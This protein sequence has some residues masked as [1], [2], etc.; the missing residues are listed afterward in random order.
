MGARDADGS[1]PCT[2]SDFF[3]QV[4]GG[5]GLGFVSKRTGFHIV[6]TARGMKKVAFTKGSTNGQKIEIYHVDYLQKMRP[7]MCVGGARRG[8]CV[9]TSCMCQYVVYVSVPLLACLF[10]L[11]FISASEKMSQLLL[12]NFHPGVR[13]ATGPKNRQHGDG[14]LNSGGHRTRQKRCVKPLIETPKHI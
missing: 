3:S 4:S 11:L 8:V 12:L 6:P 14:P 9:S 2:F 13:L 10:V 1:K 5:Q 7:C